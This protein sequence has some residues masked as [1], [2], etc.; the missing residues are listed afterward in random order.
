LEVTGL[1]QSTSN[2]LTFTFAL[3]NLLIEKVRA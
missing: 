2:L 1:F 3:V